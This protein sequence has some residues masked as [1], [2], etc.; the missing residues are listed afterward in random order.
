M[1]CSLTVLHLRSSPSPLSH[2]M[3]QMPALQYALPSPL[4]GCGHGLQRRPQLRTLLSG[5]HVI[6]PSPPQ[7]WQPRP[8]R[9]PSP[10]RLGAP[11]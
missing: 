5:S 1:R 3:P 4:A 8:Q 6:A 2:V 11:H 9:Q 7:R 10:T